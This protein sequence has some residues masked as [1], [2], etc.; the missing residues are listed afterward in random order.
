M[1]VLY[2][3]CSE[4]PL[5]T[6]SLFFIVLDFPLK[7]LNKVSQKGIKYLFKFFKVFLFLLT[8][9]FFF[10]LR[11][12]ERET[13]TERERDRERQRETDRERD[14]ERHRQR[15]RETDRETHTDTDTEREF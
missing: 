13:E 10:N 6:L 4:R 9:N 3:K 12:G 8:D 11:G 14:R 2:I 1:I 7:F 5:L 15:D